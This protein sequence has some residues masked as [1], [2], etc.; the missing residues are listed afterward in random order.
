MEKM[1]LNH[2][3]RSNVF[4]RIFLFFFFFLINTYNLSFGLPLWLSG[5][6]SACSTGNAGSIPGSGRSPGEGIGNPLQY[7]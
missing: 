2:P 5:K 1:I 7:S 6:E 3:G 4:T